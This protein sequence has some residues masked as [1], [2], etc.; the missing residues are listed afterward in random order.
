MML[1]LQRGN[2]LM[3]AAMKKKVITWPANK[4]FIEACEFFRNA[5]FKITRDFQTEKLADGRFGFSF[6]TQMILAQDGIAFGFK[7]EEL[8]LK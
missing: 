8:E 3:L 5:G 2:L 6:K 1:T 7:I 4:T